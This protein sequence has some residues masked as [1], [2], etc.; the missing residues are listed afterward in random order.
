MHNPDP[1]PDHSNHHG[2]KTTTTGPHQLVWQRQ[3]WF[4]QWHNNDWWQLDGCNN[5]NNNWTTAATTT[6]VTIA[7]T[8]MMVTQSR[9]QWQQ[10]GWQLGLS[11]CYHGGRRFIVITLVHYK[12]LDYESC[13]LVV[14]PS[15]KFKEFDEASNTTWDWSQEIKKFWKTEDWTTDMVF[16]GPG[17]F[18]SWQ[19]LVQS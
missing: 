14:L 4:E 11:G 8:T 1:S 19:V 13:L 5:D 6:M 16:T 15:I 10:L 18:W 12:W 17:N 3:Q 9:G 2:N 7:T